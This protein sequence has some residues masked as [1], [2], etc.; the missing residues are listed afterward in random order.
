MRKHGKGSSIKMRVLHVLLFFPGENLQMLNK[1]I[2]RTTGE[3]KRK[4][5]HIGRK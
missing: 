1:E 5:Q 2:R 3:I 4:Y